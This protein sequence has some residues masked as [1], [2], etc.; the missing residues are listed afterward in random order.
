MYYIP[1]ELQAAAAA[2]HLLSMILTPRSAA[3]QSAPRSV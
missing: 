3:H 1:S 2:A